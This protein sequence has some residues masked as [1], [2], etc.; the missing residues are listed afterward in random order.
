MFDLSAILVQVSYSLCEVFGL[1]PNEVDPSITVDGFEIPDPSTLTDPVAQQYAAFLRAAVPPIDPYYQFRK[2]LVRDIRYWWLTGE[3]DV[4]LLWGPTGS[5]KTSVFEQWC[6]RLGIPLFMAKGHRRFEPM[7]AFGQFVGGENGTTPWVDGPVTLAAR[8]GLPCII[9]EYDRIAADR[10]IVFNDVFE[11]RSFP[12]PGKSGEVVT[13][14]PGFRVAIT[15]NTNLVEDLSGNYGTANTHDISILE[16]IVAL[17]VGYPSDDTEAKL[18]EKEL[19]QFSDDLLSYWF[20][21]EGIKISTPQGMKEGSAINRGE[22]IQGLLEVA[23]KIRAQ[24]KDGGNTSDSALERTMSTRI[25]RK[26]ARHSVAQASAPEK[27]GLSAL[28]LALKKYLS[29]LS[30]ESTRIALHQAVEN[31]FGVGEVVKP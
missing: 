18:L 19:E 21:Q 25:L 7:E 17:H 26:W 14:Q 10:T 11:G 24:S 28:H 6:A 1:D 29:S 13:P 9:N 8:Y 22:F 12:I 4:L 27:L 20:D 15:A 3:G 31:V 2:D 30:T 23:K 16:R 5:G